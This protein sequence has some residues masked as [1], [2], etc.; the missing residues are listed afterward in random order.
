MLAAAIKAIRCVMVGFFARQAGEPS[1][2]CHGRWAGALHDCAPDPP[3]P[4]R[5]M[6]WLV[7]VLILASVPAGCGGAGIASP[8]LG[9]FDGTALSGLAPEAKTQYVY[10]TLV[11][12]VHSAQVQYARVPL[13]EYAT[14]TSIYATSRNK[15]LITSGMRVDSAGHLWVMSYGTKKGRDAPIAVFDFPLKQDS[16]PLH[17]F[18]LSG[19]DGAENI[20][21]DSSGNLWVASRQNDTVFEYKGP[22]RKSGTLSPART[23]T[24][25]LKQ[26]MGLTFD[27][28]GNLYVSNFASGGAHSIAIFK[29]PV[30]NSPPTFLNG[31]YTPGGL[32]FDKSGNLYASTNGPS[33]SAIAR[34]D[35]NDLYAGATPSIYDGTALYHSFG[36][37]FAFSASGD[38]YVS[39]CGVNASIFVYPTSTKAFGPALAP[40]IDFSDYDLYDGCAW[41]LV[42]N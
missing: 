32:L 1:V 6:K 30:K 41:G 34:Y 21:F 20:A 7:A 35:S 24:H 5:V 14:P 3:K 22:F 12:P 36:A 18:V 25:G 17:S 39:N 31:L 23:I 26:P 4:A 11:A 2:V 16:V 10:W 13:Q 33:G 27:G 38:L 15:L 37:N 40:T 29:A 19:T 28:K 42:I 9:P 8:K